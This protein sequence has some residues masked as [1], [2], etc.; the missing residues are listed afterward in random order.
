MTDRTPNLRIFSSITLPLLSVLF[1]AASA[2]SGCGDSGGG[3]APGGA[4]G[5]GG[6]PPST[7]TY[8]AD[9]DGDGFGNPNMPVDLSEAAA[10][11]VSNSGDCNDLDAAVNP[12][13]LEVC[14]GQDNDCDGTVDAGPCG[15]GSS[16]Q[17]EGDEIVCVCDPGLSGGSCEPLPWTAV[18]VGG[19]ANYNAVAHSVHAC[20]IRGGQ[21]FCWGENRYGQLGG[22]GP[23][24]ATPRRV[25]ASSNWEQVSAGGAFTCGIRSGE[26]YC[27]GSNTDG[28]RFDDAGYV[29]ILGLGDE[30]DDV[31][32]VKEPTQ[33]GTASDWVAVS[34]GT[35]HT[36]GIREDG[37]GA[38]TLWCWG[39][40]GD[41][42]VGL[43]HGLSEA[44]NVPVQEVTESTDWVSVSGGLRAQTCGI[45]ATAE[46][47]RSLWCWG[48]AGNMPWSTNS[49]PTAIGLDT[50]WSRVSVGAWHLCGLREAAGEV[51]AFCVGR[52]SHGQLG[53]GNTTSNSNFQAPAGD[54]VATN[55]GWS[56]IAA[57]QGFSCGI[58]EG[59]L[60]CWG[61]G[62]DGQLGLGQD[63]GAIEGC[64]ENHD[65]P[66]CLEPVLVEHSRSWS[67]V[68]AGARQ[69]CAIDSAS[70]LYCWG[71]DPFF[72][73]SSGT[74]FVPTPREVR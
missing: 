23:D 26:L 35:H 43:G 1:V 31:L 51:S 20:G 69:T 4:G 33:V 61:R 29:G 55:S 40:G 63:V 49:T 36:C 37:A 46:D 56:E 2:T 72:D 67:T 74:H 34:A 5:D 59:E 10:G 68:S 8:Y 21:L 71:F 57:G 30:Y 14:D 44:S 15:E 3:S 39:K 19:R 25:G 53:N 18:S 7:T 58:K 47:A 64:N 9:A 73:P 12:D 13:A 24:S 42:A 6:A 17:G 45:R 66:D 28:G 41:G 52:N 48:H 38:R 65:H 62:A 32:A 60:L 54:N 50:D 27:W 22:S 16:C 70:R 11:F